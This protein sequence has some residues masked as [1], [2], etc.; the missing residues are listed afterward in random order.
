[1]L[2]FDTA[3]F[4]G[5]VVSVIAILVFLFDISKQA[6][7]NCDAVT[8]VNANIRVT[9]ETAAVDAPTALQR[10]ELQQRANDFGTPP[11]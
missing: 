11:C 1:M 5:A 4:L 3:K 6:D 7:R 2:N 9:L 10:R 8:Q